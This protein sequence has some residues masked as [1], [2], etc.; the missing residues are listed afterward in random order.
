MIEHAADAGLAQ[1]ELVRGNL[2]A[3]ERQAE[4]ARSIAAKTG[5][6]ILL[7]GS[8]AVETYIAVTAGKPHD[9]AAT[10]PPLRDFLHVSII[11]PCQSWAW[12]QIQGPSIET[13]ELALDLLD[14]ALH[15]AETYGVTRRCIQISALRALALDALNRRDEAI[16]VLE[17]AVRRGAALGFVRSFV[18]LGERLPTLLLAIAEKDPGN[19]DVATLL[20][21]F[22]APSARTSRQ[23]Q[24]PAVTASPPGG[25]GDARS[26]D[27]RPRGIEAPS[28]DLTN[29]ELDVLELLQQRLSNKEIADRLGIS[30]A[31]VKTHTLGVY[32]KLGVRGRRQAVAAAIERGILTG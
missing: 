20:E 19:R 15:L 24:Q 30:A 8:E 1:I 13:R 17:A 22:E 11:Q 31:T 4:V 27:T 10:P 12:A 5:S 2:D 16:T 32:G 29:R 18:D 23:A 9:I 25:A 28:E 3:A 7:R 6:S 21:A 26:C 14:A